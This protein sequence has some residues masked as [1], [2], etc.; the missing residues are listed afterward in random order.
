MA[1]LGILMLFS[2]SG[3]GFESGGLIEG[4]VAMDAPN[5]SGQGVILKWKPLDKSHRIIQYKIYR[6]A[7]P[8]SLFYFNNL[9]VDPVLG[10]IGNEITFSDQDYQPLFEFETAP[11]KLKKERHQPS[12]SPLYRAV[13]RDPKVIGSLIPHFEVLGAINHRVFNHHSR[14]IDSADGSMAGYKLNQFDFIYANPLPGKTYYYSV[15]A[16]NERG[17]HLPGAKVVSATPVDNRPSPDAELAATWV[18]DKAGSV[19]VEHAGNGLRP[20]EYS[21]WLLPKDQ[22]LS[23]RPARTQLQRSDSL[24]NAQWKPVPLIFSGGRRS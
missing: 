16:V 6:G 13:P 24:F 14:R 10:V 1:L 4:L 21:G 11:N 8:D 3:A 9:D 20:Q 23:S 22:A 19:R 5:D 18:E 2:G 7:S 12:G 17:K 15:V